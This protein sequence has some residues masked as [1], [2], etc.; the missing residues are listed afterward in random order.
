[1]GGRSKE[2]ENRRAVELLQPQ[3][4]PTDRPAAPWLPGALPSLATAGRAEGKMDGD[5]VYHGEGSLRRKLVCRISNKRISFK[6]SWTEGDAPSQGHRNKLFPQPAVPHRG[7]F[8]CTF[9]PAPQCPLSVHGVPGSVL[10]SRGAHGDQAAAAG[11][12]CCFVVVWVF[13]LLFF[14]QDAY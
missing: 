7:R 8:P 13:L 6:G 4:C 9:L 1:M 12:V 3:M 14:F 2:D 11:W 10:G 5:M